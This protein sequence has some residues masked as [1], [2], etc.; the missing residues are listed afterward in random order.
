VYASLAKPT[1]N[2]GAATAPVPRSTN[3]RVQRFSIAPL[4]RAVKSQTEDRTC[5]GAKKQRH[6]KAACASGTPKTLLASTCR[7]IE[8][9]LFIR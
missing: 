5:T 7:H 8:K 3:E 9:Y 6:A 2:P 1:K 4:A